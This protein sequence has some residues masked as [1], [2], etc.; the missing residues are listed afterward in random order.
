MW[1][2]NSLECLWRDARYGLRA[3]RRSPGFTAVAVLSMALGIGANTAIFSLVRA[4]ILRVLPVREPGQL[5]E[6]LDKYPGEPRG[7]YFSLASYE[8]Y[9]D[10]NDVF[11]GLVGV[12]ASRFTARAAGHEPETLDGEC[13][14]ANYFLVLGLKPAIGRL[15][16]PENELTGRNGPAVA[17]VSSSYWKNEY[18]LDP[19]MIGAQILVDDVPLTIIGVAPRGFFG[20]QV[21]FRPDIW[22]PVAEEPAIH[23]P[24]RIGGGGLH[25]MARLKPGVSFAQARAEMSVLFQWTIDERARSSTDP[26][27]RQLR[28]EM[29]PG[30][31]GF[32]LLRDRF[33]RPLL[34]LMAL[35]SLILL[36]ACANVATMLLARVAGRQREMAVRVA[37]G[38]GRSRLV[39]QILTESLLL[40][41]AGGVPAV[42]L[43]YFGAAALVRI[44][45][46]GRRMPELPSPIAIQVSPDLHIL[47]FTAGIATLTGVLFGLAP[48][49]SVFASTPAPSLREASSA[50]GTRSGRLLG[51][52]L[53]VVQVALSVVLLSAAGLFI[54]R[55]SA[56]ER[57]DLGFRRDHVLLVTLDPAHSGYSGERLS[58]A[59][60]QLLD[61]LEAIPGVRS[62]TI[63]APSPLS[64]AG[65]SR[66][67]SVEG[68]E[69]KPEDRRY[70]SLSWVAPKYFQTL[71][72]PL[73]LGRDFRFADQGRA[74]VAIVNQAM[75]R[76]YFA[77]RNPIGRRVTLDG[78]DRAYEIVG[79]AG[80]AKYYE[81]REATPRTMYVDTFQYPAPASQFA[82]RTGIDPFAVVPE[83]RGAIREMLKTIPVVRVTTLAAQVDA[84]I[85]PERLI[86]ALSGLFGALGSTLAAIG[87]YGLLAYTV[88]R[89]TGEIGIRMALGATRAVV[90]RMVLGEAL[91]VAFGGLAMGIL[92]AYSAKRFAMT[93]IDG[94]Q[95]DIAVPIAIGSGAMIALTLAAAY[96]PARR[97]ASVHPMEALR[98]E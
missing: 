9:R 33:A 34:L 97:A 42:F 41:A 65:A 98:H 96:A 81:I 60:R 94:P 45:A 36:A 18:N 7:S 11:S 10:H 54:G 29:A 21:G 77:G 63:C 50:G 20:L 76:Y 12:S 37:L 49:W 55:L 69:E 19:A 6:L 1:G 59:Y 46:S 68:H 62:A 61:R 16:G 79:V 26:L 2:R 40:S 74:R 66:F 17:V 90:I 24:S 8:H 75:A 92:G 78:D 32:S 3:M 71:G 38:A 83:V 89:R 31:A 15:I 13:V 4:V 56:L 23:H 93:W 58:L 30:S 85:V 82:L 28:F 57:L 95:P 67:A 53:V 51:K 14:T 22:L 88:T 27:M 5:V 86:A 52:G 44:L 64:G 73:L 39:R 91:G 25:L 48:A 80:D 72:T 47:L 35:V 43:A 70:I 84:T 87:I